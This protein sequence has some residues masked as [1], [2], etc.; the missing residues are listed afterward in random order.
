MGLA[1]VDGGL[2]AR[3]ACVHVGG[4]VEE[5]AYERGLAVDR[6]PHEWSREAVGDRAVDLRPRREENL[7]QFEPIRS[8]VHSQEQRRAPLGVDRVH[9]GAVR[10][11]PLRLGEVSPESSREQTVRQ[12]L[13]RGHRH[14]HVIGGGILRHA[15]VRSR[16]RSAHLMHLE[17]CQHCGRADATGH[18][19]QLTMAVVSHVELG[20]SRQQELD[21]L[22]LLAEQHGSLKRRV[23]GVGAPRLVDVGSSVDQQLSQPHTV[24]A[25]GC[26]QHQRRA[27]AAALD[28]I[29]VG[30]LGD[31]RLCV[32][33]LDGRPV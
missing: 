32:V 17:E 15:A 9:V 14:Q 3:R 2:A 26:R 12:R 19:E 27:A 23:E 5:E 22:R 28:R 21:D 1:H 31:G 33:E 16:L 4:G 8:I 29:H 11:G 7:C 13:A 10:D 20:T 18:L 25:L 24:G 30:A 6:R